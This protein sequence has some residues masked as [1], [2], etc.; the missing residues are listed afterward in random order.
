MLPA[1]AKYEH[2]LRD[3]KIPA[4]GI[5]RMCKEATV[6]EADV[7]AARAELAAKVVETV[8][9]A[10]A[11]VA[12]TVA[13]VVAELTEQAGGPEV[14]ADTA[15]DNL[16]QAG[17]VV[18]EVADAVAHGVEIA[19]AS[20]AR[21]PARKAIE[22]IFAVLGVTDA[23]GDGDVDALDALNAVFAAITKRPGRGVVAE[24]DR[25]RE[26]LVALAVRY[27][28]VTREYADRLGTDALRGLASA[29]TQD[30]A[31]TREPGAA[32]RALRTA[33]I[34]DANGRPWRVGFRDVYSGD[35][36]DFLV[37]HH[38]ALVEPFPPKR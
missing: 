11:E 28:G 30:G 19:V 12:P 18:V 21:I 16:E 7:I 13:E 17:A 34:V 3:T 15:R 25:E 14:D 24:S 2:A 36:A 23:D 10:V 27:G 1:L 20:G 4:K 37:K 33:R 9:E 6:T 5:V 22:L 35:K 32:V 29:F 38:P 8:A 31:P 26:Q